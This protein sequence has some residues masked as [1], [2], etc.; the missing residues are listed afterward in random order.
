MLQRSLL[1]DVRTHVTRLLGGLHLAFTQRICHSAPELPHLGSGFSKSFRNRTWVGIGRTFF[2]RLNS[3][4][5]ICTLGGQSPFPARW[6]VA[7]SSTCVNASTGKRLRSSS[8]SLESRC[9]T[10]KLQLPHG[11]PGDPPGHPALAGYF[12]CECVVPGGVFLSEHVVI[13]C[14]L[15]PPAAQ[16]SQAVRSCHTRKFLPLSED[17][18]LRFFRLNKNSLLLPGQATRGSS[19]VSTTYSH[20]SRE[21]GCDAPHAIYE[22]SVILDSRHCHFLRVWPQERFTLVLR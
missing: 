13:L 20:T 3:I 16:T 17:G 5:D 8:R 1:L 12:Y 21:I 19:W 22:H 6:G 15:V 18:N 11:P 4:N 14:M 2:P 7:F 9:K 10:L